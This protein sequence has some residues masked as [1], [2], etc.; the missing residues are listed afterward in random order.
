M[1]CQVLL[2]QI[3]QRISVMS[4]M[5]NA[6]WC[7][8]LMNWAFSFDLIGCFSV[9]GNVRIFHFFSFLVNASL[10][11][12]LTAFCIGARPVYMYTI[13]MLLATYTSE[14]KFDSSTHQV[15]TS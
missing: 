13:S 10:C 3:C 11:Q 8:M 1:D 6:Y 9:L 15:Q 2:T 7:F 4:T 5:Y 12:L 14:H